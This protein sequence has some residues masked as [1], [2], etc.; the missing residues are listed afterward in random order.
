MN[1][2]I[3]A[4]DYKDKEFSDD[5]ITKGYLIEKDTIAIKAEI[6]ELVNTKINC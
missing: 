5:L 4:A 6:I 2:R 1:V 3:N